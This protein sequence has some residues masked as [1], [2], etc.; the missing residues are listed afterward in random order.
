MTKL[1]LESDGQACNTRVLV[2]GKQLDC[3]RSLKLEI[4][5][6][7]TAILTLECYVD[8]V[9]IDGEAQVTTIP[10]PFQ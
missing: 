8:E 2:A 6:Q 7:G 4:G 10:V 3:V 1:R 9:E 5:P